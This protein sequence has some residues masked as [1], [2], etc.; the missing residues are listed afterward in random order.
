LSGIVQGL[1]P[2]VEERGSKCAVQLKRSDNKNLR[3]ILA[4][5]CHKGGGPRV[6][7]VKGQRA[8]RVK[9]L[10]KMDL[11]LKCS[12]PA[13]RWQGPEHHSLREDYLDGTPRGTA[14]VPVI[15]DPGNINRVCKHMSAALSFIKDWTVDTAKKKEM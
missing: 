3:W 4:V 10:S 9:K 5:D 15:R 7:K 13:W 1:N 14:S 11:D 6:V 12:C 2:V 8:A